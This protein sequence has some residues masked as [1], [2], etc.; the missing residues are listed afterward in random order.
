MAMP[1]ADFMMDQFMKSQARGASMAPGQTSAKIRIFDEETTA[2]LKKAATAGADAVEWCAEKI[3]ALLR[4]ILNLIRKML[5][6]LPTFAPAKEAAGTDK[7]KAAQVPGGQNLAS[8]DQAL[9][10]DEKSADG[11][12]VVAATRAARRLRQ[13]SSGSHHA[14]GQIE[15]NDASTAHGGA[16]AAL[17]AGIA[18]GDVKE[19]S[20][21]AIGMPEELEKLRQGIAK[22]V[23]MVVENPA[24]FLEAVSSVD[25]S[26]PVAKLIGE[27]TARIR[28]AHD[29]TVKRIDVLARQFK[30]NLPKDEKATY[31]QYIGLS[32]ESIV[33]SVRQNAKNPAFLKVI[34][35]G[36]LLSQIAGLLDTE[37]IFRTQYATQLERATD[38]MEHVA[39]TEP[40]RF[41]LT[42]EM[43]ANESDTLVVLN[44][45]KE[46][47]VIDAK[48]TATPQESELH[49]SFLSSTPGNI[50]RLPTLRKTID[51]Y[52]DSLTQ[53]KQVVASLQASS[54]NAGIALPQVNTV[55]AIDSRP[56][57]MEIAPIPVTVV[58][59]AEASPFPCP[60]TFAKVAAAK[61]VVK[62]GFSST[63]KGQDLTVDE[64]DLSDDDGEVSKV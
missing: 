17:A 34:G 35:E 60:D 64:S 19:V 11:G 23:N 52:R 41:A 45:K 58:A 44:Q 61:P 14:E 56:V 20:V 13:E 51:D 21:N 42:A 15:S 40:E 16:V 50:S 38:L 33:E 22:W 24:R 39:K 12:D 1:T 9:S 4:W 47:I 28:F 5:G 46:N 27:E 32:P 26:L 62:S 53:S 8:Q 36:S 57:T 18:S 54:S 59:K 49:A 7:V 63:V 43:L 55:V 10:E 29:L 3:G 37:T 48:K 2:K 25:S 31:H 30:E 6:V